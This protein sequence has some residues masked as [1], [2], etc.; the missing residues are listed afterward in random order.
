VNFTGARNYV[1][2][3]LH[4]DDGHQ[5]F[6]KMFAEMSG[7]HASCTG[8]SVLDTQ[9]WITNYELKQISK[10]AVRVYMDRL[11]RD[12]FGIPLISRM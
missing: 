7:L 3:P 1:E 2:N 5:L 11:A 8:L 6:L 9:P 12:A 10:H 4:Q